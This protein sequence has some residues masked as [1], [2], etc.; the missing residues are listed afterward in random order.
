MP[1]KRK[2]IPKSAPPIVDDDGYE[3]P[4]ITLDWPSKALPSARLGRPP[5]HD[6]ESIVVEMCWHLSGKGPW[7]KLKQ[8]E[9]LPEMQQWCLQNLGT[10]PSIDELMMRCRLARKRFP[11][12]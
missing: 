7:G 9:F 4:V 8:Y 10:A 11:R 6:W 3:P 2:A 5:V 12:R 1:R